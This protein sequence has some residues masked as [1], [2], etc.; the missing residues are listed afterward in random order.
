MINK[1]ITQLFIYEGFV[2]TNLILVALGALALQGQGATV[3]AQPMQ[4]L[5]ER[6]G[7]GGESSEIL[8]LLQGWD[9]LRASLPASM[10][11][12]IAKVERSRQRKDELEQKR[13]ERAEAKRRQLRLDLEARPS[14][15]EELAEVERKVSQIFERRRQMEGVD[16]SQQ[17][18]PAE[19]RPAPAQDS[20][21]ELPLFKVAEGSQVWEVRDDFGQGDFA[22][23]DGERTD[24]VGQCWAGSNLT[25]C[26]SELTVKPLP[27]IRESEVELLPGAG[28]LLEERPPTAWE[29]DDF[30]DW[31]A[32][33][34]QFTLVTDYQWCRSQYWVL[35]NGMWKGFCEMLQVFSGAWLRRRL[36]LE[37]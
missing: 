5:S 7:L 22:Q 18:R 9:A 26:N 11:D 36:G 23:G 35:V 29:R 15:P 19:T 16:L 4:E 17:E 24:L 1:R 34:V 2:I 37:G 33:A 6:G 25:P 31:Y 32:L 28:D 8:P 10:Q 27:N 14:S 21:A 3:S 12:K 13:R 30:N 20:L